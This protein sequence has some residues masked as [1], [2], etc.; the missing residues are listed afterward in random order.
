MPNLHFR[1]VTK[2]MDVLVAFPQPTCQI[3]QRSNTGGSPSLLDRHK[4]FVPPGRTVS[5]AE[6]PE[7]K[8]L[9]PFLEKLDLRWIRNKLILYSSS[10]PFLKYHAGLYCTT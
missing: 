7:Q 5:G 4:P 1:L 3:R 9:A 8:P 6:V 2:M 10:I